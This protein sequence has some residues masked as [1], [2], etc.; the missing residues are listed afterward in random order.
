MSFQQC[1]GAF[2]TTNDDLQHI[3]GCGER[4]VRLQSK[5]DGAVLARKL[6]SNNDIALHNRCSRILHPPQ[7]RS[8]ARPGNRLFR[9]VSFSTLN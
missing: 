7:L 6:I 5:E 9:P 1:A 4:Q 8:T 3:L 2:V